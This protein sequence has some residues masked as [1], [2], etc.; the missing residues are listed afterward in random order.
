MAFYNAHHTKEGGS[1]TVKPHIGNSVYLP[2]SFYRRAYWG[3]SRER[4]GLG[5]RENSGY[6]KTRPGL[7]FSSGPSRAL[8]L[9]EWERWAAGNWADRTAMEEACTWRSREPW[10]YTGRLYPTTT[11]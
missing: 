1:I 3:P 9:L 5:V 11:K 2:L 7:K 4:I 8:D 10:V 6:M